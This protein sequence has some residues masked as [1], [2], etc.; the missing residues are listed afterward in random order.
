LSRWFC[1][2]RRR[3]T[4]QV[5]HSLSKSGI[6][7]GLALVSAMHI[8]ASV[9]VND[10]ER[11]LNADYGEWLEELAPASRSTATATA[12]PVTFC[13]QVPLRGT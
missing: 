4:P 8:T 5:D 9:F 13:V 7:E 11:G 10:D 6:R 2:D 3:I 1:T 12:G